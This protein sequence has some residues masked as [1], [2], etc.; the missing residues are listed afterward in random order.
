MC[1]TESAAY[2][3]DVGRIGLSEHLTLQASCDDG[4]RA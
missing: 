3:S 4:V 1:F 2:A